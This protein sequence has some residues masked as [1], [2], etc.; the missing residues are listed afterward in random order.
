MQKLLAFT[1]FA[2]LVSVG[3]KKGDCDSSAIGN[4]EPEGNPAGYQVRVTGSGFAADNKVR[5]DDKYGSVQFRSATE[6]FVTVPNGLVGNVNITVES[7]DNTCLGRYDRLFEVFGSYPSNIPPSPTFIVVPV[8]P[9][10]YPANFQNSWQNF[11]DNDHRIFLEDIGTGE[12]GP[13]SGEFHLTNND[14]FSN[15]PITGH[16]R[17]NEA[18]KT[19]D[20]EITIDR[21]T[22]VGGTK[23]TYKGE[24]ILPSSVT[25][26][27]SFVL[28]LTSKRD[29]RQ[30]LFEFP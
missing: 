11:I 26:L 23:E 21:S 17:V 16:F 25:S 30:F 12:L 10:V 28:L 20:I 1:F 5:F 8:V 3:C 14:F 15:N 22:K 29:G 4:V 24:L 19:T 6:L 18:A 27:G 9:T 13:Q 7:A 2:L